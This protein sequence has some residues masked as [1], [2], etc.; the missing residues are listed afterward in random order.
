MDET[1]ITSGSEQIFH[2]TLDGTHKFWR[3]R[4]HGSTQTVSFGRIGTGGQTQTKSFEDEESAR[5]ATDRIIAQKKSKGYVPVTE[6]EAAGTPPRRV[7]PRAAEQLL[8]P[9]DDFGPPQS[10]GK[11]VF[12]EPVTLALF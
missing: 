3:V 2:C 1:N 11:S 9:L 12:A 8:L 4:L 6:T 7:R 5:A 10:P